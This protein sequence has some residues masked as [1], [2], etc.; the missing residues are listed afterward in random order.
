MAKRILWG[1][2][3]GGGGRAG[4]RKPTVVLAAAM[5]CPALAVARILINQVVGRSGKQ[6]LL[7]TKTVRPLATLLPTVR[8]I[9]HRVELVGVRRSRQLLNEPAA[10]RT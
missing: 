7:S 8:H 10:G 4:E 2:P 9:G 1:E 3:G 6:L 5:W